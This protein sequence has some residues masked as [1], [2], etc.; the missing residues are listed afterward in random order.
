MFVDMD[1]GKEAFKQ[2]GMINVES[3]PQSSWSIKKGIWG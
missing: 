1:V 2:R 3:G